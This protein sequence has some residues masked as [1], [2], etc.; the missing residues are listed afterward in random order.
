MGVKSVA[1]FFAEAAT[2]S[3]ANAAP[4]MCASAGIADERS[5]LAAR[6]VV[7]GPVAIAS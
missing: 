3:E 1:V 4:A 6:V 5:A 7:T 2:V